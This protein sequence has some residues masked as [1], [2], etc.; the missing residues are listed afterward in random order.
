MHAALRSAG[1]LTCLLAVFLLAACGGSGSS[2]YSIVTIGEADDPFEQGAHLSLA[3]QLTRSATAEG[4]V[5]FDAQGRVIPAL[6]DRWIVT[7]DGKSYIFRLRDGVWRNQS[8]I[9]AESARSALREAIRSLRGTS[10]GLDLAGIEDVRVMAARV[11]EIRLVRPMPHLLQLLAQPE[12][13]LLHG[14]AG[15]GPMQFEREGDTAVL[16]PIDPKELGLPA[17]EGWSDR[18]RTLRLSG[19]DADAAVRM[20]NNGEADLLLGGRIQDFPLANSVGLLRGT[21]QLDPVIGLFGLVVMN[22]EGFLS[23]AANREAIAMAID[24]QGLI[25]PFGL[26]GWTPSTR[27]VSPGIEGDLGTIGERWTEMTIQD[28]RALAATRVSVWRRDHAGAEGEGGAPPIV[29]RIALPE[30]SGSQNLFDRLKKDL[31]EV[32]LQAKRVG[33]DEPS[34]L[35]LVD[36]IARY[37]RASWFLNR[38]NCGTRRGL[39]DKTADSRMDEAR[40][41][42]DPDERA[43]LLAEA[44]AELTSANVFIPFGSPIRWSLVRSNAIGFA[45][46]PWGWHPLMP[47]AVLPR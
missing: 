4:L 20:F 39:C 17:I 35:R 3:G 16:T 45:I 7:D 28:R 33:E 27:I 12:L 11:I 38:L 9:T 37:P 5:A 8:E 40:K 24:R 18:V 36:D 42:D 6:A 14:G 2:T 15:G 26:G 44:E 23:E 46:N 31:A 34:D 30:G 22:Q 13:A 41:T 47:M 19:M 43:A 29:L 21:I 10:L 32:G 25:E 1:R